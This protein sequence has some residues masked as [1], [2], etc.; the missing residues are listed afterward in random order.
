LTSNSGIRKQN[1]FSSYP[2]EVDCDHFSDGFGID[3]VDLMDL[4]GINNP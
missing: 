2:Y 4:S 1:T 3:A